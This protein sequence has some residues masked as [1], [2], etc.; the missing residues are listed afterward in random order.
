V[1][2]WR[3]HTRLAG[4]RALLDHLLGWLPALRHLCFTPSSLL[5]APGR[6]AEAVE[7]IAA[8]L[9]ARLAALPAAG[10][11]CAAAAPAAT[12]ALLL[13]RLA[14]GLAGRSA[15]LPAVLGPPEQWRSAAGGSRAA[16]PAAYVAGGLGAASSAPPP[17]SARCELL[18]RRLRAV[19]LQAH[20]VWAEWASAGLA[21]AFA[22]ELANDHT[23]AADA[24]L[25]AWEETV[26][27]DSSGGGG[28]GDE[29]EGGGQGDEGEGGGGLEMRFLLPAAPSPAA[30]QLAL[31]ACREADRAGALARRSPL[32]DVAV[33]C[34]ATSACPP[35]PPLP[36]P[37]PAVLGSCGPPGPPSC[38][39]CSR[40]Q[41]VSWVAFAARLHGQHL[42]CLNEHCLFLRRRSPAGRGA[43]AA[44]QVAPGGGAAGRA[45]LCAGRQRPQRRRQRRQR[46]LQ[47]RPACERG[48]RAGGAA[49]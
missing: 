14:L 13:G 17:P 21:A 22:A 32:L 27:R 23:L 30:A 28:Q 6:C 38:K 41:F 44:V 35:P 34:R 11:G 3:H 36:L 43:P 2:G 47:Q 37:P 29:G 18:Q 31:A 49:V 39:L 26:V 10:G 20:G 9:E 16:A 33:C 19:G 46:Q 8:S 48:R 7:G 1:P 15:M 5:A 40:W 12:Q 25:R 42:H 45:G 24:P 4:Q